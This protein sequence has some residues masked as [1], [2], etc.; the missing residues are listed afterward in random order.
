M[1]KKQK[2]K[3]RPRIGIALG[4]G[5]ARGYAHIGVL[6]ALQEANI[7][8]D[9]IAG[10]SMGAVV[11]AAYAAGYRIEELEDMALKMRWRWIFN[12][13]DPTLPR[14]GIIA[15]NKVEKYFEMLTQGKEFSQL[16]KP[17]TVVA[18]DIVSGE[19]VRLNEGLVAKA[20]RASIAIPGVFSPVK[21][22]ERILV[23]GSVTTPVPVR[24]AKEAGADIVIAI[25]VSSNVDQTST[26]VHTW[27]R[28]K[29][30]PS[31]K[32]VHYIKNSRF[33]IIN[34]LDNTLELCA[35]PKEVSL[36][37]GLHGKHYYLLKP[38]VGNIKWYE[39]HRAGECIRA[40]EIAGKKV[41]EKI[42]IALDT[43]NFIEEE[44]KESFW[45]LKAI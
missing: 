36:N 19:E 25:D 28:I 44:V 34:V 6:K 15:G 9:F 35:Q 26:L 20:L 12:L 1:N 11:G 13:F 7:P 18:T 30:M 39:F 38:E 41:T 16:R 42:K 45:E 2:V 37:S 43:G 23:D 5:G 17:L 8:I 31:Q 10:T 3:V 40:G 21:I 22:D 24:A 14:Q 33:E 29:N 32:V 27:K 4:S